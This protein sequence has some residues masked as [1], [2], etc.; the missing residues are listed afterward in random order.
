M[1]KTAKKIAILGTG[2]WGTALANVLISNRNSVAMW[3]IDDKEIENLKLQKNPK[4]FGKKKLCGAL[5]IVSKDINEI[6]DFKPDFVIIAVPSLHIENVL[7]KVVDKFITKPV[8]INVAK[9]FNPKTL[10][11]WSPT[12]KQLIK[13]KSSGLVTLIGP[14]FAEEVF[15]NKI[16]IVNAVTDDS[17]VAAETEKIFNSKYFKCIS[18]DDFKGAETIS[19]L[20]NVMA[21]GSGIL[22]AQHNSINT[23]SCILAQIAKEI[24]YILKVMGGKL[25]TL[26][27]FCGIG[28]IYLTCTSKKSRNFSLGLMIGKKGYKKINKVVQANTVEGYWAT[29]V[30]Y[31]IIQKYKIDAPIISHLYSILYEN[32]NPKTFV[33]NVVKEIKA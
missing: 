32:E 16:T 3:G 28:D 21:I 4:Y 24:F 9:G 19:A 29:K 31:E 1:K 25:E 12:I 30:A 6:V 8:Y 18:I 27:Q 33:N 7:S 14:S 15:K 17:K 5:S 20:K 11:T 23:R 13:G 10:K 2:A 26:Y 22:Y